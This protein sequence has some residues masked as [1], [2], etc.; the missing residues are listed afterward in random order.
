[1]AFSRFHMGVSIS[2]GAEFDECSIPQMK[3]CVNAANLFLQTVQNM[4]Y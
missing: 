4:V 2:S 3:R 1:M